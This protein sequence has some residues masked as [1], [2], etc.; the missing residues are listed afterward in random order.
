MHRINRSRFL[1][2]Q[3]HPKHQFVTS[4]SAKRI[5][6]GHGDNREVIQFCRLHSASADRNVLERLNSMLLGGEIRYDASQKETAIRLLRLQKVLMKYISTRER[7]RNIQE[8]NHSTNEP[9]SQ[10]SSPS[11]LES[12]VENPVWR[13]PRGL[14]IHGDV[15]TGKSMLMDLFHE[16]TPIQRKRRV[17]FHSF[18][19]DVHRRIHQLKKDDLD[20]YGRNFHVDTSKER[21]PIHRVAMEL[22]SEVDVLCFDEFQVTDVADALILS[23]LFTVMFQQGVVVVATSNRPPDELYENGLNRD[24]FLPFIDLLKRHCIIHDMTSVDGSLDYRML[25]ADGSNGSFFFDQGNTSSSLTCSD[26]SGSDWFFM[27]AG[28]DYLDNYQLKVAHNRMI[29]IPLADLQLGVCC[30]HFDDLCQSYRGASDYRILAEN[31]PVIVLVGVPKLTLKDHNEARRFITLVDE[32]YEAKCCLICYAVVAPPSALFET[33]THNSYIPTETPDNLDNLKPGETLGIDVAQAGGK[34]IG[35]LA[36]V[37]ELSFA[38][39]RAASRLTEL[40]SFHF[41]EAQSQRSEAA[42]RLLNK[43]TE[44]R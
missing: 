9:S 14:Y 37:I 24:Y 15:G 27:M 6:P 38:F 35:A 40:C 28:S 12:Q 39:K 43:M 33:T 7:Y 10:C 17:H 5:F 19:L 26:T 29:T 1:Y 13:V 42:K 36:S 44:K 20:T 32:L 8:E 30:V 31:F 21:N 23:Q 25:L 22:S 16:T 34:P 4:I 11:S 3:A 18:M 2:R 41:W